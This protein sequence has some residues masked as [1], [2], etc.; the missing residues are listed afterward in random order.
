MKKKGEGQEVAKKDALRKR[1]LEKAEKNLAN[2]GKVEALLEEAKLRSRRFNKFFTQ[3]EERL[4]ALLYMIKHLL[5]DRHNMSSK[6]KEEDVNSWPLWMFHVTNYHNREQAVGIKSSEMLLSRLFSKFNEGAPA[7]T[8]SQQQIPQILKT[9][10]DSD[11]LLEYTN[12]KMIEK[13]LCETSSTLWH[14]L[15]TARSALDSYSAKN[16]QRLVLGAQNL[17]GKDM[18]I[19]INKYAKI[20]PHFATLLSNKKFTEEDWEKEMKKVIHQE[21]ERDLFD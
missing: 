14:C 11:F 20:L 6:I 4:Q 19:R 9:K 12:T 3:A 15:F 13:T 16:S 2:I 17:P 7:A 1:L 18:G 10:F 5:L 21:N 8:T